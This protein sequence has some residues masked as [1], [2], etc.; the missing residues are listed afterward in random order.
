MTIP[1][2]LCL[3]LLHKSNCPLKVTLLKTRS[4]TVCNCKRVKQSMFTFGNNRPLGILFL[5]CILVFCFVLWVCRMPIFQ[6]FLITRDKK[7][8]NM[9]S[10]FPEM[11][12]SLLEKTNFQSLQK[13]VFHLP[14]RPLLGLPRNSSL[15]FKTWLGHVYHC[16][17]LAS[18]GVYYVH[19]FS[20]LWYYTYIDSITW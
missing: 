7:M 16:R 5:S 17:L 11:F 20:V 12:T 3:I 4:K 9:A 18:I 1:T 10:Q 2:D 13:L 19:L 15:S 14:E 8:D 6:I